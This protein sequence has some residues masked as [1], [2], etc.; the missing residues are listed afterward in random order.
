MSPSAMP[1]QPQEGGA[2]RAR[3]AGARPEPP[4]VSLRRFIASMAENRAM[5]RN[6]SN[7]VPPSFVFDSQAWLQHGTLREAVGPAPVVLDVNAESIVLEQLS[8][9]PPLAGAHPHFHGSVY[10]ALVVGRRRW[11]LTPPEHAEFSLEPALQ[12]FARRRGT[13][14]TTAPGSSPLSSPWWDVMQEAGDVL[15]VPMQWAHATLSLAESVAVAAE[16]V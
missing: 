14:G 16:F 15:Y 7:A 4:P 10:N 5:P 9:S 2:S 13:P 11:A 3:P 8:I 6:F 1:Y 12:Y